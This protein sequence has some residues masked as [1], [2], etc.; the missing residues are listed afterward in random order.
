[1]KSSGV[2]YL[3]WLVSCHR[4]Y[5]NRPGTNILY[6]FTLGGCGIW[7]IIDLFLIPGMVLEENAQLAA[8]FRGGKQIV[9]VNVDSGSG[10]R[11]R[12]YD[13]D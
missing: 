6:W 12:R 1:M 8:L 3:L 11:R 10:R 2:A 9:N 7:T 4:F 13:D 5:L